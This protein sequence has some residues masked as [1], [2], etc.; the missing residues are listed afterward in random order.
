[1][2][3]DIQDE[4]DGRDV[5]LDEVGISGLRY[6][7]IFDDGELTQAG[8]GN[9]DLVVCLP[10]ERRGTHMSRMVEIVHEHLSTLD[11]RELPLVLKHATAKL[12]VDSVAI[13]CA[14]PI[15]TSV[16]S[17][18]SGRDSWQASDVQIEASLTEGDFFLGTA[19]TSQVTSLCPCSQAISDYG[20]HNQRSD[21]ILRVEGDGD[22]PYPLSVSQVV[23]FI[24]SIGSCAVFPLVKRPDERVITMSAFDNPAFV[25]DMA[26]DLSLRVRKLR[27]SHA[28]SVR[29]LESIHSHDA[30]ARLRWRRGDM[31]TEL[32][33]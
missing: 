13:R 29:N 30:V 33:G 14:L 26:R 19:V 4:R 10:A 24:R 2:L 25:E 18:E 9:F 12:D 1:M 16:R 27:I 23:E 6:P 15:A 32:P 20:A 22:D 5:E 3:P 31:Q 7:T 8:I 21:V 28:V 11:P 17:P